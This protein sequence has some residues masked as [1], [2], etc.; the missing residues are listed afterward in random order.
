MSPS[1]RA[2]VGN[3]LLQSLSVSDLALLTPSFVPVSLKLKL[4]IE[5]PNKRI[6]N[7][8]FPD[9]GIISVVAEHGN[10]TKAEIGI[11]G[12]EGMSGT[13]IVLANDRSPNSTYVQAAGEGRRIA[14]PELRR[15]MNESRTLHAAFLKYV[16]VFTVQTAHTAIANAR[17]RLSERLARWLLMAFDRMPSNRVA[18]THEFLAL[19]LAVRRAGVTESVHDL[20]GRKLIATERGSITLLNRRGMEKVAGHYYGVPEAEY[21]RLIN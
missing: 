17:G 13:A 6:E 9:T 2:T 20:V 12:W 8:F 15:A 4:V 19:M 7:V 10:D 1:S 21:R 11:I 5:K 18:L 16:Q 14:A 3:R